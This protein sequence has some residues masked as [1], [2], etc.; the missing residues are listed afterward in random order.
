MGR[1]PLPAA[2]RP[3]GAPRSRREFLCWIGGAIS[4]SSRP[5][6]ARQS[7]SPPK[8]ARRSRCGDGE[9]RRSSGG[10]VASVVVGGGGAGGMVEASC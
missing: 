4:E 1:L 3:S 10:S 6:R 7:G 5:Q 8:L 9:C 2:P